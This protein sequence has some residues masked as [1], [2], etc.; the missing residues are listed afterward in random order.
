MGVIFMEMIFFSQ[1]R[2]DMIVIFLIHFNVIFIIAVKNYKAI[3]NASLFYKSSDNF[4]R[5]DMK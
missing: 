1:G 3:E 5:I 2:M 4:V